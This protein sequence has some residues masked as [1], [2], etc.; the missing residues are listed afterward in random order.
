MRSPINGPLLLLLPSPSPSSLFL[1]NDCFIKLFLHSS[2]GLENKPEWSLE[3]KELGEALFQA[4]GESFSRLAIESPSKLS[5]P[6]MEFHTERGLMWKR[7]LGWGGEPHP[8][9][10]SPSTHTEAVFSPSVSLD[11]CRSSHSWNLPPKR[12]L[13]RLQ[14]KWSRIRC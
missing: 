8:T 6:A 1:P 9:P 12:Q 10:K 3:I 5:L 7:T 2:S 13:R 4:Q 14:L 11:S